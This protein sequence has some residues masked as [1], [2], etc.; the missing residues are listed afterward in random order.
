MG[1]ALHIRIMEESRRALAEFS[2]K[3]LGRKVDL[4]INGLTV[5]S[6]HFREPLL[7]GSFIISGLE[8][9]R[10]REL[11]ERLSEVGVIVELEV[12]AE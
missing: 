7:G 8:E 11:A 3:N 4:R 2:R 10:M 6:P 9:Q 5:S 1:P 12:A